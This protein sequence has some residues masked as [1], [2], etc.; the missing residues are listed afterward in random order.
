MVLIPHEKTQNRIQ[1][2]SISL[3]LSLSVCVCSCLFSS[4]KFQGDPNKF[5]TSSFEIYTYKFTVIDVYWSI[6]SDSPFFGYNF[7]SFDINQCFLLIFCFEIGP[8]GLSLC[9]ISK[10]KLHCY[11]TW[12]EYK[13][14][15]R[16]N[17][18]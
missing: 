6:K 13:E 16:Q 17:G 3:S 18:Q 11:Y 9:Y 15:L 2:F 1:W 14:K 8:L 12:K 7:N 4:G 5:Q 10:K